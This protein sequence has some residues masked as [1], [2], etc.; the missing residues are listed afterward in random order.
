MKMSCIHKVTAVKVFKFHQEDVL[1]GFKV[2]V[3]K[4][5]K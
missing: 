2:K 1:Q 4:E 5:V 3:I